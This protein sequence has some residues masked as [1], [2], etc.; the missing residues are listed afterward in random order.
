MM[1]T[2]PEYMVPEGHFFVLGDNRDRS[3]DSRYINEV[4]FIPGAYVIG[5]VKHVIIGEY[6][7]PPEPLYERA[8]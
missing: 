3:L 7:R 2:T 6:D 1:D 5:A 4:G 8:P